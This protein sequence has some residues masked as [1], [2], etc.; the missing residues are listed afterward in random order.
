MPQMQSE[1]DLVQRIK[2]DFYQVFRLRDLQA[3]RI[4]EKAAWNL[5]R[6]NRGNYT[7]QNLNQILDIVDCDPYAPNQRWFGQLLIIPNRNRIFRS[8]V[9]SVNKWIE[10]LLFSNDAL[11]K[12][13][14]V[15]EKSRPKG[16]SKGIATL[17]LYL[18]N[19]TEYSVWLPTTHRSLEQLGR[20]QGLAKSNWSKNYPI[21]NAAAISFRDRHGFEP[22]EVDWALWMIDLIAQDSPALDRYRQ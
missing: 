13:L 5:L 20:I 21:F 1:D 15:A 9:A 17:L 8:T 22:Q 18:Q 14:A 7:Q 3:K 10:H 12:R 2:T 11:E 16:A 19:P 6:T 4:R